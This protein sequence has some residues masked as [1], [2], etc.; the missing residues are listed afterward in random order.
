MAGIWNERNPDIKCVSTFR[1]MPSDEKPQD[2]WTP[3]ALI[4]R[5]YCCARKKKTWNKS[6]L[7][8]ESDKRT[9]DSTLWCNCWFLHLH[10][11]FLPPQQVCR[12]FHQLHFRTV[13][14]SNVASIP[15]AH[16]SRP[17]D[18]L[19]VRG[20]ITNFDFSRVNIR[21]NCTECAGI[22]VC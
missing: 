12:L 19:N 8:F 13:H 17:V 18:Q 11:T 21:K 7:L 15:K 4:S 9:G 1:K 20:L 10:Y 3:D 5:T 14:Q 16:I 22:D 2:F 6:R